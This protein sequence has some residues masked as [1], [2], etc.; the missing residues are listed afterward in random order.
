MYMLKIMKIETML[1]KNWILK[2]RFLLQKVK[3]VE[4]V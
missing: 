3:T 1:E 4:L 2:I